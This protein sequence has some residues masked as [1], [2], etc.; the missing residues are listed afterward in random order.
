MQTQKDHVDAY[1]FHVARIS[2]ALVLG[3]PTPAETPARRAWVGFIAGVVIAV[4]ITI[5]FFLYGLI[6]YQQANAV[7]QSVQQ[8]VQQPAPPPSTAG[9]QE[10]PQSPPSTAHNGG[11]L[12]A[13]P[14]THAVAGA[15]RETKTVTP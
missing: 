6:A 4:L 15:P 8:S 2:S 10:R 9:E 13:P 14:T 11:R 3:D 7:R 12:Q 1:A 5:G